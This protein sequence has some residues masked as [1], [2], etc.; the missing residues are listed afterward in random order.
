MR[1]WAPP[2]LAEVPLAEV[3][4]TTAPPLDSLGYVAPKRVNASLI[5]THAAGGLSSQD[6][7]F[8]SGPYGYTN[9]QDFSNHDQGTGSYCNGALA[10]IHGGAGGFGYGPGSRPGW[11]FVGA[12]ASGGF[13]GGG[14]SDGYAGGGGG[15]FSG[16]GYSVWDDHQHFSP[17]S[18]YV[19]RGGGGGGS[20]GV[21]PFT[22]ATISSTG[23]GYVTMAL[24]SSDQPPLHRFAFAPA[25]GA[26]PPTDTGSAGGWVA[27]AAAPSSAGGWSVAT[28][29]QTT[30][31]A[32]VVVSV[33]YVV[34]PSSPPSWFSVF[35]GSGISLSIH[36]AP[37]DAADGVRAS[38]LGIVMNEAS[39]CS[40]AFFLDGRNATL[41]G[42]PYPAAA[43][44]RLLQQAAAPAA[45][46][47]PGSGIATVVVSFDASGMPSVTDGAGVPFIT[48]P[49]PAVAGAVA[50]ACAP[51]S[52][53]PFDNIIVGG[54]TA[55]AQGLPG[56]VSS[57]SV[58]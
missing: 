46:F 1:P 11:V 34:D 6:G 24:I 9:L 32:R 15:G 58:A 14:G 36:P 13:G 52:F 21:T 18:P 10:F 17:S 30:F 27:A 19:R 25:T 4:L 20:Y 5:C 33:S 54:S 3:A 2:A 47:M 31:V 45:A 51:A 49:F 38:S 22:R 39:S 55:V 12:G 48:V 35:H 29:A 43:S 26:P 37:I 28:G 16:G 41:N 23:S 42:A 7:R 56:N 50:G 53:A 8:D 44:R 40:I 57:F